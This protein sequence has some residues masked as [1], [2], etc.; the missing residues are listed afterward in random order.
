MPSWKGKTRGGLLGYKI[1][2]FI[3]KNL[4]LSPAYFV[5]RFVAAYFVVFAPS[6]TKSIYFYFKKIRHF[7]AFKSFISVYKCYYV[8]GQTILDKVAIASGM[9]DKYSYTSDGIE[10]LEELK[11]S[12][13][14]I[15]S[16]HLG[17]WD[18]AGLLLKKI[19]LK[20][21]I[22]MFE[23]EHEKIKSYLDQVMD[24]KSV[25]IIPISQDLSHIF[26]VNDALRN[27][28]VICM[29]GDRFMEGSRTMEKPFMGRMAS[30]PMGPFSIVSKLNVPFSIAF[31]VRG[32]K[33]KYHFSATPL[34]HGKLSPEDV[35]DQYIAHVETK[36]NA[37]PL[38]WFN[39]YD[40]W[41]KEVRG[42]VA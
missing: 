14:V 23:A 18:I 39:F 22:L 5:L 27:K 28:E 32:K 30:F 10:N 42:A 26:K 34:I 13:G 20:T 21:N 4:G 31:A 25:K 9:Q 19:Q 6:S 37:Y 15:I 41:S 3:L 11:A 29:H 1:F 33:K 24:N 40:F 16:A 8:F 2:I 35:L 36:L 7:G 12:G 38:Q 17:N